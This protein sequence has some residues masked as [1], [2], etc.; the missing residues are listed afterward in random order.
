VDAASTP[1]IDFPSIS[2]DT[3]SKLIYVFFQ[4][5]Q[6]SVGTE[7]RVAVHDPATGWEEPVS[8]AD[9]TDIPNGA[10]FPTSIA[11]ISGQ[12]IVLWTKGGTAPAIQA[13]RITAP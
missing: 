13:A 9:P 4:S 5:N 7:V 11:T 1:E 3:S 10:Q 2:L 8:I 12:P 6:T